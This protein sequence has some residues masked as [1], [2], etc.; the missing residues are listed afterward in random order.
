MGKGWVKPIKVEKQKQSVGIIGRSG[1]VG[2]AEELRKLSYQ[3]TVYDRYDRPGLLIYGIPNFKLEKFVVERRTKL[4]KD[5]GIKFKQNFEVGKDNLEQLKEKHDAV[6]IATGVYK[7]RNVD[8][9]E[10]I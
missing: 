9:E 8:I 3:I 1:R 5:S 4:L 6:L 2:I 10:T 7:P